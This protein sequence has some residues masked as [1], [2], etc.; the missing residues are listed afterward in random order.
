MINN[1]FT[2]QWILLEK[3][4]RSERA[5]LKE[6]L[7]IARRRLG[8][9]PLA[10]SELTEWSGH[11][12][13]FQDDVKALNSKINTFN[14]LVPILNKQLVHF[15]LEREANKILETEPTRFDGNTNVDGKKEVHQRPA[16]DSNNGLLR[17]LSDIF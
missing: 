9:T 6:K 4:I 11:V 5:T 2:P 12:A 15:Q 8:R 13:K 3:E 10:N 14:L 16:T 7:K 17:L 1:G